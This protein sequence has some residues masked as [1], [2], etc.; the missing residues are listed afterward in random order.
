MTKSLVIIF[1]CQLSFLCFAQQGGKKL[2]TAYKDNSV[3]ELRGFFND[4][5]KAIPHI[6]SS[7]YLKLN[8]TIKNVY[9][10]YTA[11]YR[12]LDIADLGGS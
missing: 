11:F 8:D 9:D 3:E 12:P 7:E 6:H 10:V 4:W 5:H 1:L 2:S